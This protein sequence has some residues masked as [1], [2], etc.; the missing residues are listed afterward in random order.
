MQQA[1]SKACVR[2]R[3]TTLGVILLANSAN[4]NNG[5]QASRQQTSAMI[6]DTH[7]LSVVAVVGENNISWKETI[8]QVKH[9]GKQGTNYRVGGYL[10]QTAGHSSC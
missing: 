5:N 3:P 4:C 10:Y 2:I 8:K 1:A 6:Q 9:G 7:R